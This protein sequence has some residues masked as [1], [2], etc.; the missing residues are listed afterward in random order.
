MNSPSKIYTPTGS[1]EY[2]GPISRDEIISQI[3]KDLKGKVSQKIIRRVLFHFFSFEFIFKNELVK[4]NSIEISN[5]GVLIPKEL[6]SPDNNKLISERRK[7]ERKKA[8][9]RIVNQKR[10]KALNEG[11]HDDKNL[12]DW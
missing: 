10:Q 11:I 3:E 8:K 12:I 7:I 4:R 9:E 5:F 2:S 1:I 6:T